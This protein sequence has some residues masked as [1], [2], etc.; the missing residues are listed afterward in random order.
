[1]IRKRRIH[2]TIVGLVVTIGVAL[3]H[4]A[5]AYWLLVPAVIGVT[6]IQSGMTG[7]CPVYFLLDRMLPSQGGSDPA[8]SCV[9]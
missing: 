8:V 1:M 6:L 9:K 4:Y 7:F 3:G 2:D 5:S